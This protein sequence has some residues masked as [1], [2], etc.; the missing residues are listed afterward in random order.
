MGKTSLAGLAV[1]LLATTAHAEQGTA[2]PVTPV[3]AATAPAPA[4][5]T[6]TPPPAVPPAFMEQFLSYDD[7]AGVVV[8]GRARQPLERQQLYLALER[9]DLVEKSREAVRR[10]VGLG[11]AGGVLIVAGVV[12]AVA[13]KLSMPDFTKGACDAPSSNAYNAVCVPDAQ[14]LEVVAASG[15]IAGFSLGG[16]LLS[17]AYVSKPDVLSKEE[18]TTLI[19]QHNGSLLRRLRGESSERG[20]V[21]V[22][23]YASAQGGGLT[24]VVTF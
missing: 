15:L 20:T 24:T 1:L 5:V 23:P 19:S 22:T 11:I 7:A 3:P 21:H 14:R 6:A 4:A 13:A 18:T 12:T 9:P 16:L 2:P 10:R 17:L 8:Q